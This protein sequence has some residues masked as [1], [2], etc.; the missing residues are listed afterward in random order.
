[1]PYF[2]SETVGAVIGEAMA[3]TDALLF[4]RRTWQ[5]WPARGPAEPVSRLPTGTLTGPTRRCF[6]PTTSWAPCSGCAK[7][8]GDVHVRGSARLARILLSE[9]LVD[10]LNQMIEPILLG[11]GKRLFSGDDKARPLVS[12]TTAATGVHICKYRLATVPT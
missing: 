12:V 7:D 3:G 8:V 4:G 5:S 2:D 10:E 9:H 11:R 6:R 1:M